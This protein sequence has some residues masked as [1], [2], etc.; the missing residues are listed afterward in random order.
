MMFVLLMES[1]S[2]G[3]LS[4]YCTLPDGVTAGQYIAFQQKINAYLNDLDSP[5]E[6]NPI[7][8]GWVTTHSFIATMRAF[9]EESDV[10]RK[11]HYSKFKTARSRLIQ[12][13]KASR[14][15]VC[16]LNENQPFKN[17]LQGKNKIF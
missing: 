7:D 10:F 17:H 15:A 6:S 14:P 16:R 9:A 4:V 12:K 3:L 1:S 8:P 2:T 5:P 13:I 11:Q